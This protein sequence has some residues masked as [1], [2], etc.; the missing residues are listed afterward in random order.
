MFSLEKTPHS[1]SVFILEECNFHIFCAHKIPFTLPWQN[2]YKNTV[3]K[4]M[5]VHK[6]TQRHARDFTLAD[7]HTHI[8]S[9]FLMKKG[10]FYALWC[11]R[12]HIGY[13]IF[14]PV[15]FY[16]SDC[17]W[18]W[19]TGVHLEPLWNHIPLSV[20]QYIRNTVNVLMTLAQV[21]FQSWL[22]SILLP[23]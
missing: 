2:L 7:T 3:P 13:S 9:L 22:C 17:E 8:M 6:R 20:S 15:T 14:S 1:I 21:R 11:L 10:L 23:Y 18:M 16:I 5:H 4:H 19:Y 12:E